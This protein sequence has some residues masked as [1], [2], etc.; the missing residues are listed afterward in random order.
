MVNVDIVKIKQVFLNIIDNSLKYTKEGNISISLIKDDAEKVLIFS[1]TDSGI[2]IT[3]EMK[4]KLFTKFGRG[5]GSVLNSGGSGLGL[6]LAQEIVKAHQG[7]ISV[8]SEGENKGSTF[9]VTLPVI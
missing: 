9:S 8:T 1:V 7:S 3:D 5:E 6:Y 4:K 2:G